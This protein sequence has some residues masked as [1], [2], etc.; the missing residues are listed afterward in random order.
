M[1]N[2]QIMSEAWSH[3]LGQDVA[4]ISM[5]FVTSP[6]EHGL[7]VDGTFI[8]SYKNLHEI[9]EYLSRYFLVQPEAVTL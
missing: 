5:G 3:E 2:A 1:S 7:W 6:R 9:D 8:V 4:I